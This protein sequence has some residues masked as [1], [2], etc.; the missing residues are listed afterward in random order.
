MTLDE[1]VTAAKT[2]TR[3]Y[4]KRQLTWW[5]GQGGWGR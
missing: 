5:R 1:A 3:H 4:V 2:A